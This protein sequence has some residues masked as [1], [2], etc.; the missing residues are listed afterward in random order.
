MVQTAL[1]AAGLRGRNS[2]QESRYRMLLGKY[3]Q[4]SGAK[5]TSCKQLNNSQ[6]ED[7]LALCESMGWRCP[8]KT[9][10][11]F[12]CKAERNVDGDIASFAQ[13]QAIRH[14]AGDLG[15]TD[16]NLIGLI[17]K[18]TKGICDGLE[19]LSSRQAWGIIECL[20]SMFARKQGKPYQTLKD[21]RDDVEGIVKDGKKQTCQV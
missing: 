21:I 11:Y 18:M 14:L 5:V 17:F 12:R 20:K 3:L 4:S 8:G 13:Q 15:W 19:Q 1:R 7:L 9:E 10:N 16:S 6:L 2:A